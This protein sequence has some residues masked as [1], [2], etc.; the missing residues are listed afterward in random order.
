MEIIKGVYR[1]PTKKQYSYL[2]LEV[3]GTAEEII[4]G[5]IKVNSAYE[6]KQKEFDTQTPP[7]IG[8]EFTTEKRGKLSIKEQNN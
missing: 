8:N 6:K 5:F 1:I 3:K 7:F 4:D 2:E